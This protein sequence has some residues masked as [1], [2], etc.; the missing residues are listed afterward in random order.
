LD[1][2]D[3]D[4]QE[5]AHAIRILWRLENDA[6]LVVCGSAADV[7]DDPAVRERDDRRLA[8]EN[9]LAAEN[10][11]VKAAGAFDVLGDDEAGVCAIPSLNVG[12]LAMVVFLLGDRRSFGLEGEGEACCGVCCGVGWEQQRGAD[13]GQFAAMCWVCPAALGVTRAIQPIG[14]PRT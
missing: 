8:G 14:S 7:D 1:V 12:R 6:R 9:D 3:A 5:A 4:V 10:V 2:G 11:A 13:R